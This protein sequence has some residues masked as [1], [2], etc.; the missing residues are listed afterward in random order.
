VPRI[1]IRPVEVDRLLQLLATS[2][3]DVD[4]E[5]DTS[6]LRRSTRQRVECKS[7]LLAFAPSSFVVNLQ[8]LRLWLWLCLNLSAL[9]Q[10]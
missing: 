3:V 5:D 8:R 9:W 1:L 7:V 6:R 10:Q 2:S 4:G